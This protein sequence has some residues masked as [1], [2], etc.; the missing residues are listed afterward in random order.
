MTEDDVLRSPE[1]GALVVRGGAVRTLGYGAGVGLTAVASILLLRH[2]GVADFGRFIT[3]TS[4]VAIVGGVTEAGL[5]AVGARDLARLPGERRSGLLGN[6]I[7]LRLILTP[8][9]VAAAVLF[10]LAVGYDDVLVYGTLLAGA[11]LFLVSVQATVALPL[12]VEL[13]IGRLTAAELLKH[14]V[15]LAAIALLVA[16]GA[17][18]LPFF[19]VQIVA[20]AALLALTPALLGRQLVTRPSFDRTVWRTLI[21]E[22]LPLALALAM[23]AVYFRLLVILCSLLSSEVETGLFATSFR[24]FEVFFG[25]PTLVVLVALPVLSAAAHESKRLDYMLRR[26][27]E[28]ALIAAT[29]LIFVLVELAEPMIRFFGGTEYLDAVPV[30]QIQAFALV[31][32]FVGQV[33]Q[34]GLIATGRQRSVAVA[35]GAALLLVLAMGLVLIPLEGSTGAAV[36]AVVAESVLACL[37]LF[38]LA[39]ERNLTPPLTFLLKL[40][41]AAAVLVAAALLPIPWVV[42]VLLGSSLYTF[43]IWVSGALPSE[44]VDAVRDRRDG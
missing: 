9:G 20:G 14:V 25:I 17:S 40:V 23:Y 18:L 43:A 6:L 24:V 37:L 2:L 8:F 29:Y 31:G 28:V 42:A 19:G 38:L 33:W 41:A 26:M 16:A 5:T 34:V 4:L 1:A 44:V 36:A 35:N 13:K 15:M 32:V 27:T 7:G 11:G 22:A 10:A 21:R 3:V 39:R 30:L 12:T